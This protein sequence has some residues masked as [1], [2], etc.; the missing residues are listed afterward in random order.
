MNHDKPPNGPGT[1]PFW[2]ESRNLSIHLR[3]YLP[4]PVKC[5]L[6]SIVAVVVTWWLS[7]MEGQECEILDSS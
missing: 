3:Y 7:D 1:K 6:L 2:A 5:W 4:K